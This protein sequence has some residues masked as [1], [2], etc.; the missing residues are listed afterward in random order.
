MQPTTRW[1]LSP[2]GTRSGQ[3]YSLRNWRCTLAGAPDKVGLFKR[4]RERYFESTRGL[5]KESHEV[6]TAYLAG[7]RTWL[8]EAQD[9]WGSADRCGLPAWDPSQR[10]L[11]LCARWPLLRANPIGLIGRDH[12]LVARLERS[13]EEAARLKVCVRACARVSF[14]WRGVSVPRC[15][16]VSAGARECACPGV[17]CRRTLR[18]RLPS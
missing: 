3:P 6:L 4:V 5:L 2:C 16:F 9:R 17:F 11:H 8:A 10:M 13:E 18:G 7:T 14:V 15:A 1:A 12:E